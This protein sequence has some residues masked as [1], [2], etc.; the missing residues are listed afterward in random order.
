MGEAGLELAAAHLLVA[1]V[2]FGT[3]AA[4]RDKGHGDAASGPPAPHLAAGGHD[5]A[6]ERLSIAAGLVV[7]D[8]RRLHLRGSPGLLLPS[9]AGIPCG[10]LLLTSPYESPMKLALPLLIIGFAV[11]GVRTKSGGRRDA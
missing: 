9:P 5:H 1:R 6:R 10:L 4:T 7:Q 2:A 11:Y 8:W 3:A